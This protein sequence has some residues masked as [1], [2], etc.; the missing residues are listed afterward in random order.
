MPDSAKDLKDIPLV[1][2]IG[3]ALLGFGI[4]LFIV[5]LLGWCGSCCTSC[6]KCLLI[7]V[8][9]ISVFGGGGG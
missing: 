5:S 3:V 6:C 7:A 4:A 8:R 2:Q 9:E 1:Y